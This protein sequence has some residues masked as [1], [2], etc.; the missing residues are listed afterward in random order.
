MKMN[1]QGQTLI[2]LLVF[3]MVA[4]I[5]ISAATVLSIIQARS[6][7][8]FTSS[9]I[10]YTV[11]ES[12]IEEAILRL[13]RN[14]NY[15]TSESILNVG[16]N[17]ATFTITSNGSSKVIKSRGEVGSVQRII[18]VDLTLNNGQIILNSW[19]EVTQ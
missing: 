3:I 13:I 12:G 9:E 19:K 18:Q 7:G 17:N 5:V 11:A 4:T 1:Q 15:T 6:V 2:V 16:G 8:R 14:P 10:A